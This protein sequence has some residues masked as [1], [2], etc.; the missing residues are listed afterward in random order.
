MALYLDVGPD[1]IL[2]IGDTFVALERKS[3][4]RARLKIIGKSEVELMRKE[5]LK[6]LAPG[7]P[8]AH[9]TGD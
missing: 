3:G 8:P 9:D 1:D 4:A 6:S 5:R 7:N 2:R